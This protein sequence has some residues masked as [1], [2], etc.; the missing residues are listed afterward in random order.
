MHFYKESK[1]CGGGGEGGGT[2]VSE[3]FLQRLQIFFLWG[4]GKGGGGGTERANVIFF[5]KNPNIK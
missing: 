1:T 5:T 2:R 3:S 4:R